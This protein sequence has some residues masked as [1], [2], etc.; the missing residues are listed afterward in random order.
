MAVYKDMYLHLFRSVEQA[1]RLLEE[2]GALGVRGALLL[3][4]KAQA[5][6]EELYLDCEDPVLTVLPPREDAAQP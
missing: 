4:R 5:D 2:R 1:A 3:L 6:C